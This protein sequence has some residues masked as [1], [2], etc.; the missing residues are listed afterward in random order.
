MQLI[1]IDRAGGM[2]S[3]QMKKD[4]GLDLR[5]FG[6]ASIVRSSLI[7]WDV[8]LQAWYIKLLHLGGHGSE[9][10]VTEGLRTIA[11]SPLRIAPTLAATGPWSGGRLLTYPEYDDAVQDEIEIIQGLRL[12]YGTNCV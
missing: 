2:S 8:E 1:K 12:K 6:K 9:F 10:I 3:L 11:L 5:Q 7:E 4:K